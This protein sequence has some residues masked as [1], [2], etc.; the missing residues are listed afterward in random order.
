M[1]KITEEKETARGQHS[2]TYSPDDNKIRITPAHRLSAE[3]FAKVRA[4]GYIWAPKQGFFVAP[5]WSPAREDVALE[6]CGEIDDEGSTLEERAAARAERFE[7]Y[8]ERRG[9]EANQTA[10]SVKQLADG[11]PFGQPILIGHHSEKR[12]R[13]DAEKIE[14]GMRRAVRLWET[15]EYWKQR[16]AAS[17]KHAERQERPDVRARRIKKLEAEKR[18]MDHNKA[19]AEKFIRY[20]SDPV[21]VCKKKDGSKPTLREAVLY[22]AGFNRGNYLESYER[23]NGYKGPLSMWEAAG[24]NIDG[25]DPEAVAIATPEEICQRG[26][27][28]Q[29]AYLPRVQRWIDHYAHRLEYERAMLAESGGTA[30]DRTKPEQGGAVKCWTQRGAWSYIVKVNKV[31]VTVWDNW[32]NGGRNFRR[33]IPFDKLGGVMSAAAVQEARDTEQLIEVI[34]GVCFRLRNACPAPTEP[35]KVAEPAQEPAADPG[36]QFD[37]MK[38]ALKAGGVKVVT[39]PQ[40]FP[41]PADLAARMVQEANIW[42]ADRILEPS[43]GTGSI[44]DALKPGAHVLAVEI[45]HTLAEALRQRP[46][47]EEFRQGDFLEVTPEEIGLFDKVLMNPPFENGADIKHI[48]HALAFLKPGGRLVALC[49][50]GPRQQEQLRPLAEESGGTYEPLPAGTFKNAGTLVNTALLIV[51]A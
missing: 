7:G 14:N 46:G 28:Q 20:W 18:R 21:A 44:L 6:L 34:A 45:N 5:S 9:Q 11:I 48:R 42:P 24:G 10:A 37:A 26:I 25:K 22:I 47:L 50:N 23:P 30:A 17:V 1:E 40:L 31:T 8:S 43:A 19:Q 33:N 35:E 39:A 3:D 12:A 32:G 16:A 13:R 38:A 2:A 41:T 15:S 51:E 4:A 36:A 49:A 29:R 27:E